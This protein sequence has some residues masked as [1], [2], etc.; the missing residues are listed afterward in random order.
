M[1]VSN[2]YTNGVWFDSDGSGSA[3]DWYV[4]SYRLIGGFLRSEKWGGG[5]PWG[6]RERESSLKGDKKRSAKNGQK[7]EREVD[8]GT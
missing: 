8:G 6:E 1:E 7:I 3:R 5:N 4:T 2:I